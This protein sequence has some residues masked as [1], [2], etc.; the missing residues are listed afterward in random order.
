MV[1]HRRMVLGK[2]HEVRA[3][4]IPLAVLPRSSFPDRSRLETR[5]MISS[6]VSSSAGS[7]VPVFEIPPQNFRQ[8]R[9]VLLHLPLLPEFLRLQVAQLPRCAIDVRPDG[10]A[11]RTP[12]P[13]SFRFR[14]LPA[15][16][17]Q[18]REAA[19]RP[20]HRRRTAA[21]P[22]T[23]AE[24]TITRLDILDVLA[25][26]RRHGVH[27]DQQMIRQCHMRGGVTRQE[28]QE[29]QRRDHRITRIVPRENELRLHWW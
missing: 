24:V 23:T 22:P 20:E 15:P 10:P 27:G 4:Q 5:S 7:V 16:V 11:A 6:V 14:L 17:A 1:R 29:R 25:R 12:R 8:F 18:V 19:P 3:A 9:I 2:L 13:A 28:E 26:V 21:S